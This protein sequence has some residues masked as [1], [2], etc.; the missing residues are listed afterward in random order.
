MAATFTMQLKSI[1]SDHG[2]HNSTS[3]R[4]HK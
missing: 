4:V 2:A 1:A 3:S